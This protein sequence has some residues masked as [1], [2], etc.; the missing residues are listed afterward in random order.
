[1]T[2]LIFNYIFQNNNCPSYSIYICENFNCHKWFL[3]VMALLLNYYDVIYLG[4][5]FNSDS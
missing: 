5:G 2:N 1:M 3:S 4:C